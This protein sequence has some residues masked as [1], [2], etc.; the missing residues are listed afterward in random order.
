MTKMS[1]VAY[2]R[3]RILDDVLKT[4]HAIIEASAGTGKTFTI[5]HLFVDLLRSSPITLEQ[6]LVVTFTEK[7]TAELRRRIRNLIEIVLIGTSVAAPV[8]DSEK[9]ALDGEDRSRLEQSLWAF[10]RAS[11]FTIHGFC[12]RVL[13]DCAFLT[14][15]SFDLKVVDA[16]Q[17]FHRAF[18]AVLRES[19]SDGKEEHA[20][21]E[22]WV[23]NGGRIDD[24]EKMLLQAHQ[25]RY[26]ESDPASIRTEL[27]RRFTQSVDI[28]ELERDY[29]SNN[30]HLNSRQLNAAVR[31]LTEL[32]RLIETPSSTL[33]FFKLVDQFDFGPLTKATNT[34]DNRQSPN[35]IA[36]F[37]QFIT[38]LQLAGAIENKAEKATETILV[39]TYLPAVRARLNR[40]KRE[41]GLVDYEDMLDWLLQALDSPNGTALLDTLR[42]RYRF[43]LADEFQDTDD[44]QWAILKRIFV[45]GTGDNRL[46][47]VGDP[48][49]AIY[50]F[51]GADVYAYLNACHEL[52]NANA[53]ALPLVTNFRSTSSL[54]DALNH[55]FDQRVEYPFFSGKIIYSDPAQCGRP[56]LEAVDTNGD[57][58]K[59]IVI[60]RFLPSGGRPGFAA[61][62][63]ESIG[64]YIASSVQTILSDAGRLKIQD[65]VG[66]TNEAETRIVKPSD[67]FVLTRTRRE[68]EEIGGYLREYGVPFSFYKLDGLF[69]TKEARDVLDVLRAIDEPRDRSL[70]LRAWGSRFFAVRYEDLPTLG[71]V[72]DSHP[73]NERLYKWS[74]MSEGRRFADLFYSLI[75]ESGL[76]ERELLLSRGERELTNFLHIMEILQERAIAERL[77]LGGII[78]LLED[79]ISSRNEPPGPDGN[80]HRIE[81][82]REAVQ[83]M[84]MHMSKGLEA[85]VVFLFGGSHRNWQRDKL[86]IYHNEDGRKF[87]IGTGMQ[88]LVADGLKSEE[89]EEDQRL[90]YVAVTRARARVFLPFF[91]E[92][93]TKTAVNGFY[94]PLNDRLKTIV[95]NI[96]AD[97]RRAAG[98]FQIEDVRDSLPAAP[99][100]STLH[101]I[102]EWSPPA[103]LL[104]DDS[105]PETI[106]DRARRDHSALMMSSYTALKHAMR[107]A[108]WSL[109]ADEFKMDLEVEPEASDLAGGSQVGIFLHD[110]IER[111]LELN[112]FSETT[113]FESWQDRSDIKQLFRDS[114]RLHHVNDPGWFDRGREVVFNTLN[115]RFTLATGRLLGPL[116][117]CN[118]IREMELIYPIPEH[119]HANLETG[120]SGSPIIERGFLKGF[121]D[122]VFEQEGLVYFA[123]WKSDQLP[124]YH[125]PALEEHVKRNYTLQAQIYLVGI[126]K[127]L[128]LRTEE[129][130]A[131]RF[132]GLLYV[133]LRGVSSD[134]EGQQGLYFHR[135]D[136][137]QVVGLESQLI[138]LPYSTS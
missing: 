130:Y 106:F 67:I 118:G 116:H 71:D 74:S 121:V 12:Q 7:A 53:Q 50:G 23:I 21:L 41:Q 136:W 51:R 78:E 94:K 43:G 9:V 19:I 104:A 72:P 68:S 137:E 115:T 138:D 40:E 11:I 80:V 95:R 93:S 87:A 127:L 120:G 70:R 56:D 29:R 16:R 102:A 96:E 109:S 89:A 61:E 90:L 27:V 97:D 112:T 4:R 49:Q 28:R 36:V 65:R 18:R 135:P 58:I 3:P 52:S 42:S 31:A 55:I 123:D 81:G 47:V 57:S 88:R 14:G 77:S 1:D 59:P 124:S 114:M 111:I 69:Q 62:A 134:N 30:L 91:S 105:E 5:E 10:D 48:K 66:A 92:G 26:L 83:V 107:P 22:Q 131:K 126:I 54:V 34:L 75:H 132:G 17:P 82:D 122:F 101:A 99:A 125:S 35:A 13:T 6:I 86:T 32:R 38:E 46:F 64:R 73:L 63:R 129:D 128:Q 45:D 113:D 2:W 117:Q 39:E 37:M 8:A 24:L 85:D 108:V 103:S 33:A 44:V 15:M 25:R 119:N 100:D 20:L 98:L 110:V 133:F 76:A 79:Y 84:T 60:M